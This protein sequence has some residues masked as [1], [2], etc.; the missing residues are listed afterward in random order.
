MKGA[1]GGGAAE[2]TATTGLRKGIG[3]LGLLAMF[4]GLNIGGALFALTTVAAGFSGPALPLAML[5]SALPVVLAVVPYVMLVSVLPTTSATYRYSQL[6][7]PAVAL[8]SQLTLLVCILIGGQPLFALAFGKYLQALVPVDPVLAGA[9]V[10]TLFYGVN[11]LGVRLTATLQTILF[12]VLMFALLLYAAGGI[13]HVRAEHF[14]PLFP[15]GI[16]GVLAAA[17]LLFTFSAGG[18]FVIDVGG[19]VMRARAAF[20]RALPL[21]M[22]IAVGIYV[23]ITVVTVGTTNW[24]DLE[25]RSLI[26]IA[27]TFLS[28]PMLACF[29]VGGALVACAT[30][31]N[32]IFTIVSRGLLVVS[33]EGL[34]PGCVGRVHPRFATPHWGLTAAYLVC[35]VS[36][37]TV[38]SLMFFGSMLNL[39]LVF[40]ITV[41][42]LAART[43][44]DRFPALFARATTR[45]SRAGTRALCTTIVV[46]NTVI[47]GFFVFAI[48]KASLVFAGVVVMACVYAW[49]KRVPL[50]RIQDR[51]LTCRGRVDPVL[52]E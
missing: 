35:L 42:T 30:T 9:G 16:G 52:W 23:L 8:I 29:I 46:L 37:V 1:E 39:G 3:F 12:F 24:A 11:L 27:E 31:I 34:I 51:L 19:E 21:G 50:R 47:F 41:V 20:S 18:L 43:F 48:G 6:F 4:V 22:G 49:S 13:P 15:R 26:A 25:G 32:I 33:R 36:L 28:G 2:G 17:G 10:L 38:P 7:H 5:V 45:L 44:P 40:C 14:S